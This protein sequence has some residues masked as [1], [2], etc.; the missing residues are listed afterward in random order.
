M[1][2]KKKKAGL[3]TPD[4]KPS[5]QFQSGRDPSRPDYIM[6]DE[7]GQR[8]VPRDPKGE[9]VPPD[10]AEGMQPEDFAETGAEKS[11]LEAERI[12]G[13]YAASQQANQGMAGGGDPGLLPGSDVA[14][15][16]QRDVEMVRSEFV[17]PAEVKRQ[18]DIEEAKSRA[19]TQT[20]RD[21]EARRRRG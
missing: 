14:N 18:V 8:T 19:K 16:E 13:E 5:E 4:Y 10:F 17:D 12:K 20:V 15:L 2:K 1:A 9:Y 3:E 7:L 21:E 11:R 6:A